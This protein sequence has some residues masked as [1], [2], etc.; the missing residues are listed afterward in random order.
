MK[1]GVLTYSINN[2]GYN[3]PEHD[4]IDLR[5]NYTIEKPEK[6]VKDLQDKIRKFIIK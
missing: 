4:R 2:I 5:K 6:L 1:Y 3:I